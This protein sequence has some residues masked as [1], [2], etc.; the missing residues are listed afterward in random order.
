MRNTVCLLLIAAFTFV[1]SGHVQGALE[2]AREGGSSFSVGDEM[3]NSFMLGSDSSGQDT[4]TGCAM[5]PQGG[6]G[7]STDMLEPLAVEELD[8]DSD[9]PR[10]FSEAYTQASLTTPNTP[11]NPPNYPILP[12]P[13]IPPVPVPVLVPEPATVLIFA[14]GLAGTVPF[15]RKRKK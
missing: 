11:Y 3:V 10:A 15:F 9:S 2:L 1:V 13:V 6:A 12:V 14:L 8:L 7:R 5:N 4:T